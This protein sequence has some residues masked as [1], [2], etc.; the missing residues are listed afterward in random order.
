M[1]E[2]LNS[3]AFIFE[4]AG[5]QNFSLKSLT[6]MR[7][8]S[9]I[10]TGYTVVLLLSVAYANFLF[11]R[12]A[13][14]SEITIKNLLIH[15][16][17]R[18]LNF[19]G[20]A[21]VCTSIIESFVYTQ[22]FM[23]IFLNINEV[24]RLSLRELKIPMNLE[25]VKKSSWMI[26]TVMVT[27]LCVLHGSVTYVHIKVGNGY[28]WMAV[29]AAPM[30]LAI[31]INFKLV[32]LINLTNNQ[33]DFL[34]KVMHEIFTARTLCSLKN[35]IVHL[36]PAYTE[37]YYEV[38]LRKLNAARKIYNLLTENVDL[39]NKSHGLTLLITV[40]N[41]V[42]LI[43]ISAFESMTLLLGTSSNPRKVLGMIIMLN[44]F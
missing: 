18:A 36:R 43:N 30:F 15:L 4:V 21:I 31:I 39:V 3:I 27:I 19:G 42:T 41:S 28:F 20:T 1:L 23:K 33:L 11:T 9:V 17:N 2:V 38:K 44:N 8:R 25:Q 24:S 37:N 26:L 22:N 16:I 14:I 13:D 35:R 10:R 32:F 12:P 7:N 29:G 5:L 40:L 34:D 6:V